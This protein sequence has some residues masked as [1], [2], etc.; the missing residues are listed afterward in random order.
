MA[1]VIGGVALLGATSAQAVTLLSLVNPP[2]TTGTTYDL[3]LTA[4]AATTTI[5]IG[6]YWPFAY[7][8]VS[9]NSVTLGGGAN[10]LGGTWAPTPAASG[11][12]DGFF[13]DGTSVPA[14]WFGGT[15]AGYYDTLSQTFATTPGDTYLLTFDFYNCSNSLVCPNLDF[16]SSALLVTTTARASAA[17]ELSTWTMTLFGCLGLGLVGYRRTRKA[18]LL[19]RP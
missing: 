14:L 5:S 13:D 18:Q 8:Y 9:H 7:E 12:N 11:S 6:G 1:G 19:S 2:A 15:S 4:T 3:D 10:L 16:N 17:P